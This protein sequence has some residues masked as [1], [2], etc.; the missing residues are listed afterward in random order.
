M[1]FD[2]VHMTT[3]RRHQSKFQVPNKRHSY[4][5]IQGFLAFSLTRSPKGLSLH[6][7]NVRQTDYEQEAQLLLGWPTVLPY[8]RRLCESCGAFMQIGPA[9][10]S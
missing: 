7:N 8:S 10:F 3:P 1:K 5:L 2:S 9:V 4:W 6:S